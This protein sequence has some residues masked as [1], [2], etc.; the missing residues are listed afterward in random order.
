MVTAQEIARLRRA[1]QRIAAADATS[2]LDVASTLGALQGQDTL[3]SLWAIG[4]RLHEAT[5][6][7]IEEEVARGALV[8]T[9]PMRGTL[10]LIPAIDAPWMLALLAPRAVAQAAGRA[11]ALGLDD[12]AFARART[13]VSDALA[14]GRACSR[15]GLYDLFDAGGVSS[16]GQRGQHI[17]RRLAQEG[18]ICHGPRDGKQP[19]LMLLADRVPNGVAKSREEALGELSRRY[20]TSHGPATVQDFM[21]WSG[22]TSVDAKSGLASAAGLVEAKVGPTSYWMAPGEHEGTMLPSVDLLPAFDEYLIGYRDRGA[23]LDPEH[24]EHVCPGSNGMFMPMIVVN[25]RIEGIWK[26]TLRARSVVVSPSP[27]RRLVASE[28]RLLSDAADR[29]GRFL[30]LTAIVDWGPA[31]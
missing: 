22:L 17:I 14:G 25:G 8:R 16:D 10:H 29:Y 2:A 23:V 15:Q 26:R 21:W 18:L 9:W 12:T 4:L 7:R 6:G 19:A 27:F 5:E 11:R 3:G 1:N 13:L 20:F 24:A 30:G 31:R 28:K